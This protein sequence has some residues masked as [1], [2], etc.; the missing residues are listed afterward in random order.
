MATRTRSLFLPFLLFSFSTWLD[1]ANQNERAFHCRVLVDHVTRSPKAYGLR[2]C[3]PLLTP[4]EGLRGKPRPKTEQVAHV[5][6]V[7]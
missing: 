4:L 6:L 2:S 5:W 1:T 7:K 3:A